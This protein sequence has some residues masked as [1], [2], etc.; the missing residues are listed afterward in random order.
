MKNKRGISLIVLVITII[1]II[2]LATAVIV[3]FLKNNPISKA[4]EAVKK[5]NTATEKEQEQ[6][7]EINWKFEKESKIATW[8]ED[9]VIGDTLKKVINSNNNKISDF[10]FTNLATKIA[11]DIYEK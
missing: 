6:L 10:N 1:V 11:T 3:T 4:N 5:W 8:F 2:V 9:P 7:L